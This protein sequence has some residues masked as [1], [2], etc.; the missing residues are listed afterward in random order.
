[1][2]A[3]DKFTKGL[4]IIGMIFV[5]IGLGWNIYQAC[6]IDPNTTYPIMFIFAGLSVIRIGSQY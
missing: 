5:L 2:Q 6:N 3:P 1:M 4:Y